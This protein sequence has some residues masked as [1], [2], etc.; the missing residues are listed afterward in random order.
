MPGLVWR[1]E[2][3]SSK[4]KEGGLV[5]GGFTIAVAY[6][7]NFSDTEEKKDGS[8]KDGVNQQRINFCFELH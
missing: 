5:R 2:I 4:V 6:V 1:C 8:W 3:S 7:A